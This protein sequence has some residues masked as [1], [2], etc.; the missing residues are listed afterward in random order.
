[1]T[2]LC[3]ISKKQHFPRDTF[4]NLTPKGTNVHRNIS[5]DIATTRVLGQLLFLCWGYKHHK[6]PRYRAFC[7]PKK[8]KKKKKTTNTIND[9]SQQNKKKRKKKTMVLHNSN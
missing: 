4:N 3:S 1:L 9:H 8:K 2:S 5:G 7:V 6:F